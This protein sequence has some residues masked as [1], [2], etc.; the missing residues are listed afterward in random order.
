MRMGEASL[1]QRQAKFTCSPQTLVPPSVT[2][3]SHKHVF[4]SCAWSVV[5]RLL[6]IDNYQKLHEFLNLSYTYVITPE[7]SFETNNSNIL[8]RPCVECEKAG[9]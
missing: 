1:N 3:K 2:V 5:H 7:Y 6:C 4:S 8:T 9:A